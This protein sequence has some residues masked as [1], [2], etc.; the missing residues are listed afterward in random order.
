MTHP[1]AGPPETSSNKEGPDTQQYYIAVQ[2]NTTTQG[3]LGPTRTR[4]YHS[5]DTTE[6]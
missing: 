3:E 4:K 5:T 6:E 1:H 2:G